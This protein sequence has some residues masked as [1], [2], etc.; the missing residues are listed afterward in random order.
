[1]AINGRPIKLDAARGQK[2]LQTGREERFP[3][4]TTLYLGAFA[5]TAEDLLELIPQVKNRLVDFAQPGEGRNTFATFETIED[6]AAAKRIISE[7]RP[8]LNGRTVRASW[9]AGDKQKPRSQEQS[10]WRPAY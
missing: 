9:A 7:A 5:G 8:T 3:P 10:P 2:T 4:S 6:A 1:F